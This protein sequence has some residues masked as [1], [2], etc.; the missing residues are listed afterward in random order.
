MVR[1]VSVRCGTFGYVMSG[2]VRSRRSGYG[3]LCSVTVS[4]VKAVGAC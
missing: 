2:S 3:P 4:W 1:C